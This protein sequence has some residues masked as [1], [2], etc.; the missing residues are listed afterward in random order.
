[1]NDLP[2]LITQRWPTRKVAAV[3]EVSRL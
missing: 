1:M 3:P 2:T